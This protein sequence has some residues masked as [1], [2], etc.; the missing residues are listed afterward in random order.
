MSCLLYT[1]TNKYI[2]I[3][4]SSKID[5]FNIMTE[6]E[7]E[8]ELKNPNNTRREYQRYVAMSCI[9]KGIPHNITA[10]IVGVSYRTINRWA[11]SCCD[12]G[13][14]KLKPEFNGG[15]PSQLTNNQKLEFGNYLYLNPGMSMTEAKMYL[16]KTYNLNFSLTHVINI[17]ESLRFNYRSHRPEFIEAPENKEEILIERISEAEITEN[18]IIVGIDEST[19][20]TGIKTKKGIYFPDSKKKTRK[21]N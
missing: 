8:K 20:K 16:N 2:S 10:D 7:L 3:V 5:I 21:N 13:I 17:V 4:K 18:D 15:R 19:M 6:E 9:A 11:N 12:G 1:R 14:D